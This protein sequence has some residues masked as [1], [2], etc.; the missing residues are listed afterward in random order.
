MK[1]LQELTFPELILRPML[2]NGV[3]N[4][5]QMDLK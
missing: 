4:D 5:N 2:W 1:E 3:A